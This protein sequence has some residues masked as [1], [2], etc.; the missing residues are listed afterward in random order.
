MDLL[1]ADKGAYKIMVVDD[2]EIVR[3]YLIRILDEAGY[4]DITQAT[5]GAEALKLLEEDDYHL[6]MLD[7]QMPEVDGLET[8]RRG[9]KQHPNTQF[10]IM[11]AH[12]SLETAMEAIDSGAFNYVTKPFDDVDFVLSRIQAALERVAMIH[13]NI[14]MINRLQLV[15]GKLKR[16]QK[17][18]DAHQRLSQTEEV[19]E[20]L[21]EIINELQ[22]FR[23][24]TKSI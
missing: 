9:K 8:L 6:L 18:K 24:K 12:S 20:R 1:G 16:T 21:S 17:E 14:N 23:K 22:E 15:V 19:V 5:T 3:E 2:S 13:Y 4:T 7:I 10:I 11:T